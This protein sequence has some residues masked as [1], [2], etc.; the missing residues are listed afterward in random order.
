MDEFDEENYVSQKI[1][2]L[3]EK[4][5]NNTSNEENLRRLRISAEIL[6]KIDY[7]IIVAGY[8]ERELVEKFKVK[9]HSKTKA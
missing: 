2:I 4:Y 6:D 9:N 1:Q 8:N 7:A 3:K 5:Q